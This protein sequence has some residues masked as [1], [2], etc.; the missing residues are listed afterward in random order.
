MLSTWLITVDVDID[1]LAVVVF[2]KMF[3]LFPLYSTLRNKW[4]YS[5]HTWSVESYSTS[6]RVE[7]LQK[8]FGIFW[9][10]FYLFSQI[11][12]LFI[13]SI[14]SLNQRG[15]IDIYYLDYDSVRKLFQLWLLRTLTL[16]LCPFNMLHQRKF[17]HFS[18]FWHYK[19]LRLILYLSCPSS[20]ICHL[21]EEP[22]IPLLKSG[23]RNKILHTRYVHCL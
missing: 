7:Y 14:T 21:S 13:Y 6:L 2:V 20:Q 8:L 10:K 22:G 5:V 16:L 11:I 17:L 19:M 9:Q 18:P 4:H 3:Y 12:Y 15:F 1:H 23:N